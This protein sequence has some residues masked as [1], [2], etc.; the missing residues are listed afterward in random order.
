MQRRS[1]SS[2]SMLAGPTV[3]LTAST[4]VSTHATAAA[5]ASIAVVIDAVVLGLTSRTR[6]LPA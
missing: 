6:T 2:F 1:S 5:V 3:G 4:T